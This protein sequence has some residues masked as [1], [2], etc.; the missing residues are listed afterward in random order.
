LS[1]HPAITMYGTTWCYESRR[2]KKLLDEN[3]IEYLFIDID[4]DLDGR[5]YVEQVNRGFRSVPT[6]V[7]A[8][9]SILVE[10]SM[11]ILKEK[12]GIAE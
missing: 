3:G 12:L 5:S 11:K 6:I 9:G 1:D 10:P 2:A 7:F 4:S 8:D